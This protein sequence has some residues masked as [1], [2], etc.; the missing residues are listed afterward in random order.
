MSIVKEILKEAK[1]L[2]AN[3]SIGQTIENDMLR[4]HL[5]NGSLQVTDLTNAGKRGKT[6]D[7]F[8]FNFFDRDD[9][10]AF[11]LS[12]NISKIKDYTSA[13]KAVKKFIDDAEKQ[14]LDG[15]R[16]YKLYEYT[17]KG[18]EVTPADFKP[19][20]VVGK[21]VVVNAEYNSFSVKD[22]S[23]INEDTCIPAIEGGKK[24]IKVFY[25]WVV[26]NESKIKNMTF[27]DI[28]KEMMSN[29]IQ[30]HQYCAMD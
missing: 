13:L 12:N 6:V 14:N 28:V 2:K 17:L 1:W 24:D 25:R 20:K 23:D 15:Y 30:F 29:Q 7:Y 22:K 18:V 10:E 4:I 21:N 26:D 19:I 16:G 11:V 8:S 5:Y 27:H 9:K 3:I